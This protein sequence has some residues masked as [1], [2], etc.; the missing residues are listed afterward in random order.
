M[1][2]Y[3]YLQLPESCLL[4]KR[5]YKKLFYEN[6]RMNTTDKKWFTADIEN[7]TWKYTLKP[8]LTTIQAFQDKDYSY[9]EI[10]VVELIV[11]TDKHL[12]RLTD[13]I[14]R[15]IPYPLLLVYRLESGFH[16]SVADKRFNKA[17]DQAATIKEYWITDRIDEQLHDSADQA[18]VD[19]LA[20]EKQPRLNL[21]VFYKSWIDAFIAYKVSRVTGDFEMLD[22]HTKMQQRIETLNTYRDLEEQ[23]KGLR[24]AL[25]KEEAFNEKVK[26]NV[27]I[28][29]LEKQLKQT[30]KQL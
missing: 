2:P 18:F 29:K 20:Y 12:H 27:D 4:D 21:K 24:T 17:D 30:T 5:I 6:A 8:D 19:Q 11:T 28:K 26:L 7:I 10:A 13:I 25:K 9:D 14:H 22:E 15:S 23:I 1:F 16:L 3:D